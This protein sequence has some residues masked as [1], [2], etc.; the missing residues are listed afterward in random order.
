MAKGATIL[1]S[2]M[3]SWLLLILKYLVSSLFSNCGKPLFHLYPE[4]VPQV[5]TK[6]P[7]SSCRCLSR[8]G[9]A[10]VHLWS[11][12]QT[13]S[14]PWQPFFFSLFFSID[15]LLFLALTLTLRSKTLVS[16]FQAVDPVI[17]KRMKGQKSSTCVFA[18][19]FQELLHPRPVP[20]WLGISVLVTLN[21]KGDALFILEGHVL[22]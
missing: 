8:V 7:L 4:V 3:K 16:V 2:K 17:G 15:T 1:L 19:S 10:S 11:W 14:C 21:F 20:H 5:C 13:A 22:D 6:C 12:W 9:R 18:G